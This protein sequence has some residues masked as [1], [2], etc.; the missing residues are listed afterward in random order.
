MCCLCGVQQRHSCCPFSYGWRRES[1][2]RCVPHCTHAHSVARPSIRVRTI[3]FIHTQIIL[4]CSY[5]CHE[6]GPLPW[7][8]CTTAC[9]FSMMFLYYTILYYT[10]LYY[11]ILY[12]TFQNS[13][14]LYIAIL[15]Y[16]IRDYP[17]RNNYIKTTVFLSKT[18]VSCT[19][20]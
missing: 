1:T 11:T 13:S 3:S 18:I 6:Y 7:L 8:Q 15:C 10:I 9:T 17:I 20:L 12:Y 16:T 4:S 2:L 19:I 14:K 5:Q